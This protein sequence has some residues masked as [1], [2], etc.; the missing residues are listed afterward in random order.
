[1]AVSAEAEGESKTQF[2]EDRVSVPEAEQ[3]DIMDS[4]QGRRI[5]TVSQSP[6][7][8]NEVEEIMM[9][10]VNNMRK[11][12]SSLLHTKSYLMNSLLHLEDRSRILLQL[13]KQNNLDSHCRNIYHGKI[14]NYVLPAPKIVWTCRKKVMEV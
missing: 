10:S 7:V 8:G 13:S 5:E 4:V 14:Y 6:A 9:K 12:K 1:M 11:E 3:D 2:R